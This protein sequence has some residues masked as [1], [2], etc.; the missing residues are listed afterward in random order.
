MVQ[1]AARTA[2]HTKALGRATFTCALKVAKNVNTICVCTRA[3][4]EGVR[5]GV[6]VIPPQLNR[7]S[8]CPATSLKSDCS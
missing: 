5:F 4:T 6:H 8:R 2:A 7:P 1:M 3:Q